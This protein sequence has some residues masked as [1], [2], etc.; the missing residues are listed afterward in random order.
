VDRVFRGL[1]LPDLVLFVLVLTLST[2]GLVMV[3]SATSLQ[4]A[5]NL[6][7]SWFY[8][9]R[10]F[11]FVVVGMSAMFLLSATDYRR[12]VRWG[13]FALI[14]A[15]LALAAVYVP[16]IGASGGG[17]QRWIR[18][19]G[20]RAQPAEFAKLAC[21]L[22]M[23]WALVRKGNNVRHLGYGL[24]PMGLVAGTLALLVLRQPDFGNAVVLVF[25]AGVM[26]FL[27][28]ARI[29][30]LLG[31]VLWSLPFLYVLMMGT[32]Y[33]RRRILA[34]LDPWADPQNTSYQI[35]QSF[36]AFSQG[37]LWGTGLGNSQ[38]KLYYLPEIHTDFIAALIGEELG[39]LGVAFIIALFAG[40]VYRGFRIAF[41]AVDAQGFLL[42]AGC[43]TLIATQ[44]LLNL[45]VVMGLLPT[46]GLP[47]P[48]LSHGGSS[49]LSM[50][51]AVGFLQSVAAA[52]E[53]A[54]M[55]LER[56]WLR[57][58]GLA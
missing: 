43:T 52:S 42:A 29:S 47:L 27:A 37:G 45:C 31:A 36:T 35:L 51:V 21:I 26:L 28:G 34:F 39:L 41:R 3:F 14:I 1:N 4:A 33:R 19:G 12:L 40:L 7:D 50:Y 55:Q 44:V 53:H 30:Y 58:W 10:Q 9:R 32:E 16:G 23:T 15:I 6:G 2:L 11:L 5:E 18:L 48:F 49:L 13:G 25:V 54:P 17:A 8:L 46:K 57:R 20:F 38:E 24:L 56:R 22:Y